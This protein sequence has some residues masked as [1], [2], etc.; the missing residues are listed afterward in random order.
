[1]FDAIENLQTSVLTEMAKASTIK[2]L[3]HPVE[4]YCRGICTTTV[5]VLWSA[6]GKQAHVAVGIDIH[7]DRDEN[8]FEVLCIVVW[9]C[10]RFRVELK[11]EEVGYFC[12]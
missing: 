7:R 5:C 8:Y 9:K 12:R 2:L 4:E 1:M 3:N 6:D 11:A 10:F